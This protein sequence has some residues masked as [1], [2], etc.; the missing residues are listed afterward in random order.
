MILM[1]VFR[2][3][4]SASKYLGNSDDDDEDN[5]D[6]AKPTTFIHLVALVLRSE[7]QLYDKAG[8]GVKTSLCTY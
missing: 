3:F 7:L 2:L 6:E 5:S 1:M 8:V 4:F